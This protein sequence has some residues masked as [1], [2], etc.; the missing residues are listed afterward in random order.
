VLWVEGCW[1]HRY[2]DASA[3]REWQSGGRR[4]ENV[5]NITGVGAGDR[6]HFW[7]GATSQ[8]YV[9][10]TWWTAPSG[11]SGNPFTLAISRNPVEMGKRCIKGWR[12]NQFWVM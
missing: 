8:T 11:V 4:L 7:G 10:N 12:V 6:L 2:V 1:R 9:I 3:S 5:T